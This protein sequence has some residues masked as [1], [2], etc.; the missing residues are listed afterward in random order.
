MA[1]SE[2]KHA[3]SNGTCHPETETC[4]LRIGTCHVQIKKTV[5]SKQINPVF[6]LNPLI[7]T[8]KKH[9]VFKQKH[10]I[11]KDMSFSNGIKAFQTN[12]NHFETKI[13]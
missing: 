4:K 6:K 1:F 11:F 7:S 3:I 13:N 2:I 10:D 8:K 5:I 9:L 12:T